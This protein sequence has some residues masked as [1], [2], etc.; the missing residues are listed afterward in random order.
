MQVS[1][2]FTFLKVHGLELVRLGSHPH[3]TRGNPKTQK[4]NQ[5]Q[6]E[7]FTSKA[8]TIITCRTKPPHT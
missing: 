5:T 2:N 1:R 4:E 3:R 7:N 8:Q 6:K